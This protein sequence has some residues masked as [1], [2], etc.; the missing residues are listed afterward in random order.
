M[1]RAMFLRGEGVYTLFCSFQE[2][3]RVMIGLLVEKKIRGVSSQN[4]DE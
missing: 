2:L 4:H 3:K 1:V